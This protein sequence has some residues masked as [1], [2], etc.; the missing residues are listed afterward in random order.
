MKTATGSVCVSRPARENENMKLFQE[1]MR[2]NREEV[3]MPGVDSRREMREKASYAAHPSIHAASSSSLGMA[4][5]LGIIIQTMK[6]S[7]MSMC[8][9]INAA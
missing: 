8:E 4:S 5:K 1:K 6:G 7:A 9:R 3:M 2:A